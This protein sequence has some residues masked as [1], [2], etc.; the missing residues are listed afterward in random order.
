[1]EVLTP[2][3]RQ[4]VD[5][6]AS[7][8]ADSAKTLRVLFSPHVES[9]SE[10]VCTPLGTWSEEVG[11][12]DRHPLNLGAG[13]GFAMGSTDE[14]EAKKMQGTVDRVERWLQTAK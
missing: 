1:M 11:K 9:E 7:V 6:S 8:A 4:W 13:L 14:T 5:V 2:E 3:Q 12:M 10:S